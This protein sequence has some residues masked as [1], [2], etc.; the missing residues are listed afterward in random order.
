VTRSSRRSTT[1]AA[2]RHRSV[3]HLDERQW[4][5]DHVTPG[6]A[7]ADLRR[8][9][10]G[11]VRRLV[12]ANPGAGWTALDGGLT[13]AGALKFKEQLSDWVQSWEPSI[14]SPRRSNGHRVLAAAGGRGCQHHGVAVTPDGWCGSSPVRS[15]AAWPH[16][17]IAAWDGRRFT[18]FDPT[19]L[20]AIE[21]NISNCR[22]SP[23][24]ARLRFP[25]SGLLI[26]EPGD[27]KGR[28]ITHATDCPGADRAHVAGP[29]ARSPLLLVPTEGGLA[30]FR[31]I[32][33]ARFRGAVTCAPL[34]RERR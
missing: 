16:L 19:A 2:P 5:A 27:P 30:V 32:P 17:R 28:R 13:T 8:K 3:Q 6:S 11:V 18:Y 21:Y 7:W 15:R 1:A 34:S 4:Y 23:T 25:G 20:G 9:Q 10:D 26:W 24:Q 29:H 12:R 33:D 14:R 31:S 22:R